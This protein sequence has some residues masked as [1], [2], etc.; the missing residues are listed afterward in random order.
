MAELA[1]I[2]EGDR[3]RVTYE[4]T[5]DHVIGHGKVLGFAGGA[6][7]SVEGADTVE[8]LEPE[9]QAGRV[10][11]DAKG[12]FYYKMASCDRWRY[13]Y[14]GELV[15]LDTPKRPLRKLVPEGEK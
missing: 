3:V 14:N 12:V 1:D 7:L 8:I 10:Y 4:G 6:Y 15:S 5:V 9:Y 13:V 11:E 2:K